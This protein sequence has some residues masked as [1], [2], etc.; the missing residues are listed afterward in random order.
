MDEPFG[1]IDPVVRGRLQ[2]EL[3]RL[4][5]VLHKTIVFVTHDIDEAVRLGDRIALFS[6]GGALEQYAAPDL[7]LG[8]PAS[9][10]VDEFLGDGRM[11]RRLGLRRVRSA[12]LCDPD[13]QG[14]PATAIDADATLREALDAVLGTG[15]GRVAVRESGRILGII[16][17]ESI[18]EAVR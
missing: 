13:G 12:R 17:S 10:F 4:Q 6:A 11:V 1:A 15:D 2:D 16:D 5:Q 18:R 8:A 3:L 9:A 7:L 14:V